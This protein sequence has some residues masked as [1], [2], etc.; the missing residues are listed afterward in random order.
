MNALH[1]L[2]TVVGVSVLVSTTI[3]LVIFR[4]LRRALAS[5][6]KNG[7]SMPFWHSFTI[8]MLYAVPLF[9]A[10]LW[11]PY[12]GN[13]ITVVRTALAATLFGATSGLAVIGLKVAGARPA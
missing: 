6:C 9:F 2:L 7:E 4:P 13:T 8:L 10:L 11:T 12:E 3:L 5:F 1:N